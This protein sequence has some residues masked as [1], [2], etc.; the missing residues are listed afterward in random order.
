MPQI[1]V[2]VCAECLVHHFIW[3][4]GKT[5]KH[6]IGMVSRN[7]PMYGKH[8]RQQISRLRKCVDDKN[9]DLLS[10][11]T[12]KS[13]HN[14]LFFTTRKMPFLPFGS[15]FG[16]WAY[17]KSLLITNVLQDQSPTRIGWHRKRKDRYR[18]HVHKDKY[19]PRQQTW[20]IMWWFQATR[21]KKK[22][23]ESNHHPGKLE[24]TH[25]LL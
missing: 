9:T 19:N 12:S 21:M 7:K 17:Q 24:K 18:V 10:K 20:S 16:G 6:S 8:S 22:K 5:I 2:K 15:S 14:K 25:T 1:Q 4:T 11:H 13:K 3:I 23:K